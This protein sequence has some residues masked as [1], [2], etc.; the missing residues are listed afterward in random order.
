MWDV[1]IHPLRGRRLCWHT[2]GQGLPLIPIVTSRPG[3]DHF[4]GMLHHR[5]M[6]LSALGP[7]YAL[8]VFVF[9]NSRATSQWVTH[10]GSALASFSLNFRVPTEPEASELPKGLMLG[11]NRNIHLR[12]TP[13]GDVG[14]YN[15]IVRSHIA[16]EGDPYMY[17]PIPT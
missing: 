2:S 7:D 9:R 13:M 15:V 3:A 12:I 5:S 1:T 10:L 8:T 6:I 17:I 11:K 14:S 16:Q 4:P